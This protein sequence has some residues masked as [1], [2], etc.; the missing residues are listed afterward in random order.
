[1]SANQFDIITVFDATATVI[2]QTTGSG[3]PRLYEG[4]TGIYIYAWTQS[5][6][7]SIDGGFTFEEIRPPNVPVVATITQ[8]SEGIDSVTVIFS[9]GSTSADPG[10]S[11]YHV[12]PET[13]STWLSGGD[14]AVGFFPVDAISNLDFD[15]TL[16][17]N[18]RI[19]STVKMMRNAIG[20]PFT[21]FSESDQG[22]PQS[23]GVSGITDVDGLG[24]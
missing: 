4:D 9:S 11:K 24:Q 21:L 17:G 5:L 1:M 12:G 14:L 13:S 16:V 7:K 10:H 2:S 22:L 19:A 20:P 18:S 15:P 6:K 23:G 3:I 8:N